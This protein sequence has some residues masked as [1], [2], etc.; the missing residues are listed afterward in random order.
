MAGLVPFDC[1][2]LAVPGY[3]T[4]NC[5]L[6]HQQSAFDLKKNHK[7]HF[8]LRKN[9]HAFVMSK[10]HSLQ[11]KNLYANFKTK[12][13]CTIGSCYFLKLGIIV[14]YVHTYC[15]KL[16]IIELYAHTIV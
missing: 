12:N 9:S 8:H 15:L 3:M 4:T 1:S 2:L 11:Y 5:N 13:N 14:L 7:S 16:K 10:P 6:A